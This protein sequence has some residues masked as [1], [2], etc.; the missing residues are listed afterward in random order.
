MASHAATTN[1]TNGTSG[2]SPMGSIAQTYTSTDTKSKQVE[3]DSSGP[4]PPLAE[5]TSPPP[6]PKANRAGVVDALSQYAQRQLVSAG[7]SILQGS[8]RGRL[9]IDYCCRRL[10]ARNIGLHGHQ[11]LSK[12]ELLDRG[13]PSHNH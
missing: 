5:A 11:Q 7:T 8:A 2:Q 6:P 13:F 12:G 10:K 9:G 1:G 4:L 3:H